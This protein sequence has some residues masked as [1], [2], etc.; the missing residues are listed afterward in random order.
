MD[1][2]CHQIFGV[3]FMST[4]SSICGWFVSSN[5]G[6]L[7]NE[8]NLIQMW[9]IFVIKFCMFISRVQSHPNVDDLCHFLQK[10]FT[11]GKAQ[12]MV[13][14]NYQWAYFFGCSFYHLSPFV[15][16]KQCTGT[17][18]G[19]QG[20]SSEKARKSQQYHFVSKS[21]INDCTICLHDT[22]LFIGL[23]LLTWRKPP[24]SQYIHQI[25][26]S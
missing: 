26:S 9:R 15:N 22:V 7:F 1:D 4:I 5:F 2:L 24:K 10:S 19:T 18:F 25:L 16:G 3:Y 12:K 11:S 8:Y 14:D 20:S 17:I 21:M 23:I 6:C 13:S